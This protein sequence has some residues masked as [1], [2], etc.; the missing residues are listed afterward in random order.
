MYGYNKTGHPPVLNTDQKRQTYFSLLPTE[1]FARITDYYYGLLDIILKRYDADTTHF[2]LNRYAMASS[3]VHLL[4]TSFYLA[5][6][7]R[8]LISEYE[9]NPQSG[10]YHT[11]DSRMTWAGAHIRIMA[12]TS[13]MYLHDHL[14]HLF[15]QKIAKLYDIIANATRNNNIVRSAFI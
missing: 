11:K 5:M 14:A 12:G 4:D 6:S 13:I 2:E 15:W 8:E 10:V 9:K 1:L 7:L 3:G